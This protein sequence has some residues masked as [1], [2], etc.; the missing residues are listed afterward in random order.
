MREY[1]AEEVIR[2]SYEEGPG[3]L[4]EHLRRLV[5]SFVRL[6]GDEGA[7]G[8]LSLAQCHAVAEIGR[9]GSVA[10]KDLAEALDID[11]SAASRLV[12]RLVQLA[13]VDRGE[14]REDR[15]YIAIALTPY[16][17]ELF[18]KNE[19]ATE[20]YFAALF[21]AI[22]EKD[23]RGVLEGLDILLSAVK[24]CPCCRTRRR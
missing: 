24:E 2:V 9:A 19:T 21:Q 7:C 5:R 22:P 3:L 15:R 12:D 16:G 10:L 6:G 17:R 20:R 8:V 1:L 11:K 4:R 23:R 13:I 14:D 18:E